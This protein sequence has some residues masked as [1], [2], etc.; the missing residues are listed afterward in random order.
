M[1]S[2]HALPAA[3]TTS[4]QRSTRPAASGGDLAAGLSE[5]H[6]GC[7]AAHPPTATGAESAGTPQDPLTLIRPGEVSRLRDP[8]DRMTAKAWL[9]RPVDRDRMGAEASEPLRLP[10]VQRLPPA[11]SR[12]SADHFRAFR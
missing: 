11:I 2:A 8:A 10:C 7:A 1:N 6:P 3:G 9:D 12:S 4:Q 5:Q